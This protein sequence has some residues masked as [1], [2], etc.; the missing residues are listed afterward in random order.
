MSLLI[1]ALDK[2]EKAQTEKALENRLDVANTNAHSDLKT[3]SKDQSTE[4]K[5]PETTLLQKELEEDAG[6]DFDLVPL[7]MRGSAVASSVAA[8]ATKNVSLNELSKPSLQKSA[9]ATP[10]Q[11]ANIFTS[12]R[13]DTPNIS[14]NLAIILGVGLLAL[15]AIV[16]YFYPYLGDGQKVSMLPSRH[17]L[18]WLQQIHLPKIK[19]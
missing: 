11:A 5:L 12:K 9:A 14:S 3:K 2:A 6:L 19:I 1:K 10:T 18:R 17:P 7:S 4:S 8:E 13:F 16:V 15:L